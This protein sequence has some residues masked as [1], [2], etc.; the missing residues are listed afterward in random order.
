MVKYCPLRLGGFQVF[1]IFTGWSSHLTRRS[2]LTSIIDIIY[3]ESL[4]LHIFYGKAFSS[5]NRAELI[6]YYGLVAPA[7]KYQNSLNL[8]LLLKK[9]VNTAFEKILLN[10]S[11]ATWFVRETK[12]K[13]EIFVEE[14]GDNS[15]I[16]NVKSTMLASKNQRKESE[17]ARL[18]FQGMDTGNVMLIY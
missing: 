7:F 12:D 16:T 2:S 14:F 18:W 11:R 10:K 15:T 17:T 6:W 3:L 4:S 1:V 13:G 5:A 8:I 9:M